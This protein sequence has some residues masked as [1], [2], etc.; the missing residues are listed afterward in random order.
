MDEAFEVLTL[1]QTGKTHPLPVVLVDEPGGA[2][3]ETWRR[4]LEDSL[5]KFGLIS[6]EDFH[7]FRIT[8]SVEEAV[9]E[10]H[11]FYRVFHRCGMWTGSW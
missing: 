7:L 3:W 1:L 5:L 9:R 10:I 2:Y 8:S 4:F 11:G 6:A